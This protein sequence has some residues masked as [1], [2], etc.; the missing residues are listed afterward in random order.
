MF[1]QFFNYVHRTQKSQVQLERKYNSNCKNMQQ[2]TTVSVS[3]RVSLG[4]VCKL[5]F[6]Q[7]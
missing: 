3:N 5:K 1:T 6:V 4:T 7:F 2:Y